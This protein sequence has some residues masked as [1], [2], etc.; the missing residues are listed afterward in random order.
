MDCRLARA[1]RMRSIE[2]R[3]SVL[4]CAS[5]SPRSTASRRAVPE[6]DAAPAVEA[7]PDQLQPPIEPSSE[8]RGAFRALRHRN[9]RLYFF[10]QST[11]LAGT[12]MQSAAQLWLVLELTN[13][14]TM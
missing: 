11:S 5:V 14:A 4:I 6:S 13:S 8:R 7:G 12:W 2:T 9:Y 10:G 3:A 1:W